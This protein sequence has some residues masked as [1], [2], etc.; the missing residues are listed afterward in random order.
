MLLVITK[1]FLVITKIYSLNFSI[2]MVLS[3][4][5]FKESPDKRDA[6]D[7]GR[8]KRN[9]KSVRDGDGRSVKKRKTFHNGSISFCK[10]HSLLEIFSGKPR[11]DFHFRIYVIYDPN[12]IPRWNHE[13]QC[14][15]PCSTLYLV[16][17]I[18]NLL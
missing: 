13:F 6:L 7:K 10:S 16:F 18:R 4:L 2:T 15:R 11:M 8:V 14:T 3:K 17:H 5:A 9:E 12:T 1:I